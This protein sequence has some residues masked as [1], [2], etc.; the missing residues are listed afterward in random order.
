MKKKREKTQILYLFLILLSLS[1]PAAYSLGISPAI[2]EIRFEPGLTKSLKVQI[3]GESKVFDTKLSVSGDLKEHITL[4]QESLTVPESGTIFEYEVNLPF[5]LKPG[6]HKASIAIEQ[7]PKVLESGAGKSTFGARAAV[8]HVIIVNVPYENKYAEATIS[9]P[10]TNVGQPVD[11]VVTVANYGNEDIQKVQGV[12]DILDYDSKS[13]VTIN[14][15]S[16]SLKR[17]E[18]TELYAH[19]TPKEVKAGIYK[20]RVVV[21]YDGKQTKAETTFLVGNLFIDILDLNPKEFEQDKIQ[22]LNIN[23]KSFWSQEVEK[24]HATINIFFNDKQKETISTHLINLDPWQ[25]GIITAF[26]DTTDYQFGEYDAEVVLNYQDK[27]TTKA[28]G[29][30]IKGSEK[31]SPPYI[32][33]GVLIVAGLIVTFLIINAVRKKNQEDEL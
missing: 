26:W 24:I 1:L 28:F 15:D 2:T 3:F 27:T 20:A 31:N 11:F 9:A 12:I 30:I 14:T 22:K 32:L 19:W 33:V 5:E 10:N 16:S 21:D 4:Q 17:G 7:Q 6:K 29:L 23:I 18:K 13:V 8:G 25:T